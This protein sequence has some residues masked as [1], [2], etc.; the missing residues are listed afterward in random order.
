MIQQK[1]LTMDV[2]VIDLELAVDRV[3]NLVGLSC[4][5]YICVSNVHMC[6][7][8]FDSTDFCSVVIEFVNFLAVG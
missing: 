1:I 7:E 4:G 3:L 2:H 5:A 8:T 6:M